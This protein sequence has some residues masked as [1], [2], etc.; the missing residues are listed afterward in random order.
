MLPLADY[1]AK[2]K[3]QSLG[4]AGDG[5]TANVM[6]TEVKGQTGQCVRDN[7]GIST[8]KFCLEKYQSLQ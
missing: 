8:D 2:G 5:Q 6:Y 7:R 1:M 4:M 3:E